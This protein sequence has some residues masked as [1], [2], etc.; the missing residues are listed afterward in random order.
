MSSKSPTKP[1]AVSFTSGKMAGKPV[2]SGSSRL[3]NAAGVESFGSR[4]PTTAGRMETLTRA[5]GSYAAS[6]ADS[7]ARSTQPVRSRDDRDVFDFGPLLVELPSAVKPRPRHASDGGS[8]VTALEPS[9]RMGGDGGVSG[10]T[11][12]RRMDPPMGRHSSRQ[13]DSSSR[14]MDLGNSGLL[15][16]HPDS[17]EKVKDWMSAMGNGERAAKF[18]PGNDGEAYAQVLNTGFML[19]EDPQFGPSP[20]APAPSVAMSVDRLSSCDLTAIGHPLKITPSHLLPP[21]GLA[22]QPMVECDAKKC[23][24]EVEKL[25]EENDLLKLKYREFA[26]KVKDTYESKF[27]TAVA[28]CTKQMSRAVQENMQLRAKLGCYEQVITDQKQ[29][30]QES[31]AF[32]PDLETCLR[33]DG[34]SFSR[35]LQLNVNRE[36]DFRLKEDRRIS[37]Q[38]AQQKLY[39]LVQSGEI[40]QDRLEQDV[41]TDLV[42]DSASSVCSSKDR[43]VSNEKSF[44]PDS[45]LSGS[46]SSSVSGMFSPDVAGENEEGEFD[47]AAICDAPVL[48]SDMK[49]GAQVIDTSFMDD[50]HEYFFECV[51]TPTF[52]ETRFVKR[53]RVAMFESNGPGTDVLDEIVSDFHFQWTSLRMSVPITFDIVMD[54]LSN[55][56]LTPPDFDEE[57]LEMFKRGEGSRVGVIRETCPFE[58]SADL[59]GTCLD[60]RSAP[61]LFWAVSAEQYLNWNTT[62]SQRVRALVHGRAVKK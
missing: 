23:T 59:V 37:L 51:E 35:T 54:F 19:S 5:S 7:V 18:A 38:E 32:F 3:A 36:Q 60:W 25:T 40:A 1:P 52:T 55:V 48:D 47:P 44:D 2:K 12:R 43:M 13:V 21:E 16:F 61:E 8:F 49:R 31:L 26:Q 30:I 41:S 6:R 14:G 15:A 56:T 28:E 39:G 42:P 45:C 9:P 62:T 50:F 4:P 58:Y 17:H 46:G 29:A 53:L 27:Q 22:E 34:F 11:S 10:M 20:F 57:L 24:N 33:D